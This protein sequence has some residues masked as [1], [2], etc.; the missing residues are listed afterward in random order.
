[1]FTRM[2]YGHVYQH[3]D[4]EGRL[5]SQTFE[6]DD[7]PAEWFDNNSFEYGLCQTLDMLGFVITIRFPYTTQQPERYSIRRD[8]W[9]AVR[10]LMVAGRKIEA[11]KRL[12]TH[13]NMGLL[14]SKSVVE[15]MCII[16][17][18]IQRE[19]NKIM[20]PV[21]E[22]KEPVVEIGLCYKCLYRIEQ[23]GVSFIIK[24]GQKIQSTEITG[25]KLTRYFQN[26]DNC[27]LVEK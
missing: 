21:P 12:R 3:Y 15:A 2:I 24:G 7:N 16:D 27:P 13:T 17:D 22:D 8:N 4:N 18:T 14:E 20:F 19:I 26:G 23:P 10:L 1:M 25:C 5:E 9:E 11:I 6:A